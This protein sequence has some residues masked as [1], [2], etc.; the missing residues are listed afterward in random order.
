M[1]SKTDVTMKTFTAIHVEISM[2]GIL[3]GFEDSVVSEIVAY[4]PLS[5]ETS[6]LYGAILR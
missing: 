3:S 1:G 4:R 5:N 6:P 2:M